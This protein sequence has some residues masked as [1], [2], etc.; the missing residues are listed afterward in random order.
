MNSAREE[1]RSVLQSI[2]RDLDEPPSCEACEGTGLDTD[3]HWWSDGS[4]AACEFCTG[5]GVLPA[6][7]VTKAEAH[8]VF[9]VT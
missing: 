1:R 3:H 2:M 7:D 4:Y 6:N 8:G 5:Y 9:V